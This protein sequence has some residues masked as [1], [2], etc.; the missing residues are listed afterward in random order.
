MKK[1]KNN[2]RSLLFFYKKFIYFQK[3]NYICKQSFG[4]FV[5]LIKCDDFTMSI[6]CVILFTEKS[7]E[8]YFVFVICLQSLINCIKRDERHHTEKCEIV[9]TKIPI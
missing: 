5:S 3:N 6:D 8:K 2:F 4:Y 7:F 1:E 9:A